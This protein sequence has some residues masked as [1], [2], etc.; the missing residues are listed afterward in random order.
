MNNKFYSFCVFS[1]WQT[2]NMASDLDRL[3][4][5]NQKRKRK[6]AKTQFN[7]SLSVAVSRKIVKKATLNLSLNSTLHLQTLQGNNKAL[8]K[9]LEKERYEV[10]VLQE[11]YVESIA[12]NQEL[13]QRV[14][15]LTHIVAHSQGTIAKLREILARASKDLLG[16]AH[17]LGDAITECSGPGGRN[18]SELSDQHKLSEHGKGCISFEAFSQQRK[19]HLYERSGDAMD[20]TKQE[21]AKASAIDLSVVHEQSYID[22][23]IPDI[24]FSDEKKTSRRPAMKTLYEAEANKKP[25]RVPRRA[26]VFATSDNQETSPLVGSP[27]AKNENDAVPAVAPVVS[28]DTAKETDMEKTCDRDIPFDDEETFTFNMELY[29]KQVNTSSKSEQDQITND[30]NMSKEKTFKRKK[31]KQRRVSH[32][33]ENVNNVEENITSSRKSRRLSKQTEHKEEIVNSKESLEVIGIT[34]E[35]SKS[36]SKPSRRRTNK[37]PEVKVAN[38]EEKESGYKDIED[39][40]EHKMDEMVKSK[41]KARSKKQLKCMAEDN[42][43]KQLN[44]ND[45]LHQFAAVA[46]VHSPQNHFDDETA[47]KDIYDNQSEQKTNN[48]STNIK[49]HEKETANERNENKK[50]KNVSQNND[51]LPVGATFIPLSPQQNLQNEFTSNSTRSTAKPARQNATF[52]PITPVKKKKSNTSASKPGKPKSGEQIATVLNSP[53]KSNEEKFNSVTFK[54]KKQSFEESVQ[55]Q[56]KEQTDKNDQDEAE[57]L[58]KVENQ[59]NLSEKNDVSSRGNV[60]GAKGKKH[61]RRDTY[62]KELELIESEKD[63]CTKQHEGRDTYKKEA[64]EEMEMNLRWHERRATYEKEGIRDMEQ[65]ET[66]KDYVKQHKRRGTYQNEESKGIETIE[67]ESIK[68]QSDGKISD[69]K[70]GKERPQRMT[71]RGTYVAEVLPVSNNIDTNL[72]KKG[73]RR[74]TFVKPFPPS[75]D[76]KPL[77]ARKRRGTYNVDSD[78]DNLDDESP[79]ILLDGEINLSLSDHDFELAEPS[80]MEHL[81]LPAEAN[82]LSSDLTME[83]TNCDNVDMELTGTV[84]IN[85]SDSKADNISKPLEKGVESGMDLLRQRLSQLRTDF[86]APVNILDTEKQHEEGQTEETIIYDV[87]KYKEVNVE[88]PAKTDAVMKQ[89]DNKKATSTHND[90]VQNDVELEDN[91]HGRGTD[92]NLCKEKSKSNDKQGVHTFKAAESTKISEQDSET[93]EQEAATTE[94]RQVHEEIDQNKFVKSRRSKLDEK[95]S[96]RALKRNRNRTITLDKVIDSMP[97]ASLEDKENLGK[98]SCHTEAGSKKIKNNLRVSKVTQEQTHVEIESKNAVTVES[99]MKD[100]QIQQKIDDSMS[101]DSAESESSTETYKKEKRKLTRKTKIPRKTYVVSEESLESSQDGTKMSD[102]EESIS[103]KSKFQICLKKPGKIKFIAG[104]KVS[105]NPLMKNAVAKETSKSKKM[106]KSQKEKLQRSPPKCSKSATCLIEKK[107]VFDMSAN[108]S[109][110]EPD[111]FQTFKKRM[112]TVQIGDLVKEVVPVTQESSQNLEEL[113]HVQDETI[114]TDSPHGIMLVLGNGTRTKPRARSKQVSYSNKLAE[115]HLRPC[116][117][118][119]GTPEASVAGNKESC[120]ATPPS[121]HMLQRKYQEMRCDGKDR[122]VLNGIDV[123][124]EVIT[125]SESEKEPELDIPEAAAGHVEVTSVE[126]RRLSV[127][128][129][130]LRSDKVNT[131]QGSGREEEETISNVTEKSQKSDIDSAISEETDE[132]QKKGIDHLESLDNEIEQAKLMEG[133]QRKNTKPVKKKSVKGSKKSRSVEKTKIDSPDRDNELVENTDLEGSKKRS[134]MSD[135]SPKRKSTDDVIDEL[136]KRRRRG[137]AVNYKESG[138]NVK[139]R[140]GDKGSSTIYEGAEK[141]K[142]EANYRRDSNVMAKRKS[143]QRKGA[144]AAGKGEKESGRKSSQR[145]NPDEKGTN[146]HDEEARKSTARKSSHKRYTHDEENVQVTKRA[147]SNVVPDIDIKEET[148]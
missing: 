77:V 117:T 45:N 114:L 72:S 37:S 73:S 5:K 130:P 103:K 50:E 25:A 132:T 86:I 59:V 2:P 64:K 78:I 48:E 14:N 133:K 91:K 40:E 128:I 28:T 82:N 21:S 6:L 89:N 34:D 76:E 49:T 10:K 135:L 145:K 108:E 93:I 129:A 24:M 140:R 23:E 26:A 19:Y 62:Q 55:N 32:D 121:K 44:K 104:R 58:S 139:L 43:Q 99:V 85:K 116:L 51:N 17:L 101:L 110:E 27:L 115:T 20:N 105:P 63:S 79:S 29:K 9:S 68:Q 142:L 118:P 41:V 84:T 18:S 54:N 47:K 100:E 136:P 83:T 7:T 122:E 96:S 112:S 92:Y 98:T 36:R 57:I 52:I 127:D 119:E 102:N 120:G 69:G 70:I 97:E 65:I 143:S 131:V 109:L 137:I 113:Q 53:R 80:A 39:D 106:K 146:G 125:E 124:E 3:R 15:R 87:K 147:L 30:S 31:P 144:D 67:K 4:Q 22:S 16:T 88:L 35:P 13:E 74:D 33:A 66:E 60:D 1:V 11:R 42:E 90:E 138:I 71:R 148:E 46:E 56:L 141:E 107:S 75:D 95:Q 81:Q 12:A 111:T 38:I 8:A 61:T 123:K 134:D 126:K 94:L